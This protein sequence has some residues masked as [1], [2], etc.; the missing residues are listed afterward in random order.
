MVVPSTAN[1]F[2]ALLS[3]LRSSMG[4]GMGI[5]NFTHQEDR[6]ARLLVKNLGSGMPDSAVREELETLDIR[7]QGVT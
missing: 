6:Y 3:T 5:H 2:R 7:V 4:E 1:G